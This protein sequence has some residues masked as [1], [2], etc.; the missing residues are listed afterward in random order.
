MANRTEQDGYGPWI[1]AIQGRRTFG[2]PSTPS[3]RG[4]VRPAGFKR[5]V[6]EHTV[7]CRVRARGRPFQLVCPAK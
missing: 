4:Y 6:S 7:P 1:G 2:Y 5:C 3:R